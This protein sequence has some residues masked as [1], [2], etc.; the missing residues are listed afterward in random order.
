MLRILRRA[1]ISRVSSMG[2]SC[3]AR[4][5]RALPVHPTLGATR[6]HDSLSN[7]CHAAPPVACFLLLGSVDHFGSWH[8]PRSHRPINSPSMATEACLYQ[9]MRRLTTR[10]RGRTRAAFVVFLNLWAVYCTSALADENTDKKLTEAA[11]H[12]TRT[13]FRVSYSVI[14]TS[15]I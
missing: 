1:S 7:H 4:R 14:M 11:L 5:S 13:S 10:S 2:C 12:E 6:L 3:G 15:P 9:P 8:T